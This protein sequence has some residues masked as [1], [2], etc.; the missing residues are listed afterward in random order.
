MGDINENC[1]FFRIDNLKV[2]QLAKE[3]LRVYGDSV[4]RVNAQQY[5][6]FLRSQERSTALVLDHDMLSLRFK[7][8]YTYLQRLLRPIW[9]LKIS[10]R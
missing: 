4:K 5:E 1:F 7:A 10:Y 8:I 9:E 6:D 3:L 2:L